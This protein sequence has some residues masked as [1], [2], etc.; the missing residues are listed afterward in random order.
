M[1]YWRPRNNHAVELLVTHRGEIF[2][3]AH[4]VCYGRVLRRMTS[5][6]HK[7]HLQLQRR[8]G[9]QAYKIGLSCYFQRH[10]VEHNNSK[11][12][13]VLRGGS[14]IVHHEDILTHEYVYSG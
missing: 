7:A 12:P 2:I 3:K 5:Q 10:K 6:L 4:H 14:R 13:N 1:L 11:G 8:V 9:K